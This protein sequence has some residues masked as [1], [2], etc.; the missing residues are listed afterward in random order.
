MSQKVHLYRDPQ[1][2][3]WHITKHSLPKKRGEWVF[4][5]GE[6]IDGKHSFREDSMK[7]VK[8]KID[9]VHRKLSLIFVS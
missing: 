1:G 3:D 7:A 6:S 4:W 8:R 5:I 2:N 9:L